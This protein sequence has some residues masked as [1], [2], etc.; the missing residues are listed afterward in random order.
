[1]MAG[2][3]DFLLSSRDARE[4]LSEYGSFLFSDVGE[5][6]CNTITNQFESIV[7]EIKLLKLLLRGTLSDL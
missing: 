3:M 4:D 2:L 5:I 1:M 7:C 6:V